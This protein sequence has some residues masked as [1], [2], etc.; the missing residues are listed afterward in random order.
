M[1]REL[2][3]TIEALLLSSDAPLGVSRIQSV[4]ARGARP[5]ADEVKAALSQLQD[6]C[7]TRGIEL[8]KIGGAYRYQS[9]REYADWIAKL[10]ETRPPRL[11][12]ALLETLAII[13]YRQPVTRAD[14]EEIRGV[15]VTTDIMRR[16]QEREWI[17]EAG[18]RDL[19][20]RPALFAT[21]P[22]FLSYF[23]LESLD[24]LP[25]L[26]PQRPLGEIAGEIGGMDGESAPAQTPP[27][28]G[29]TAAATD[30]A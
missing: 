11:S 1:S 12:R 22:E 19:P 10:H 18:A 21:T 4:F 26:S 5:S 20:G 23:N 24:D 16:L 25:P 28:D 27:A 3:N 7:K 14:I 30:E 29:A 2:Q 15:G 8:R 17:T 9:R 13:A 6:E